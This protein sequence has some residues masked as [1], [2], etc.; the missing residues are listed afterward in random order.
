MSSFLQSVSLIR[1]VC[2]GDKVLCTIVLVVEDIRIYNGHLMEVCRVESKQ[3][4][5]QNDITYTMTCLKKT[6][7]MLLPFPPLFDHLNK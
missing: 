5:E 2:T 3:N 4:V 1:E 6:V 7:F